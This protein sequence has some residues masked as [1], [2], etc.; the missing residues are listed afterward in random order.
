MLVLS[1]GLAVFSSALHSHNEVILIP[2]ERS[3]QHIALSR[4]EASSGACSW[5][6]RLNVEV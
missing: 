4:A 1:P 2:P 3:L 6:E 5:S